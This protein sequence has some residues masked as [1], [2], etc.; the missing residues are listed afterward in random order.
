M[1]AYDVLIGGKSMLDE[2]GLKI[3]SYN[4]GM[5]TP[6]TQLIE[7][8]G[9][10]NVVDL[11][12]SFGDVQYKQRPVNIVM[13]TIAGYADW[14]ALLSAVAGYLHGQR[15]QIIFGT[16]V[17]FYYD[18]RISIDY[19]KSNEVFS[20][21]VLKGTAHPYKKEVENSDGLWLWDPFSFIDGVI[22][23]YANID[24]PGTVTIIGRR[25]KVV[26]VFT[27]SAAMTVTYDS[28][29][30]DLESGVNTIYALALGEG[31]H[32][33]TFAGVGTVSVAYRGGAL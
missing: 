20:T 24:S 22:R 26:P 25:E 5:P 13:S 28:V 21:I 17:A 2:Y 3:E 8:T 31:E 12:E 15:M 32:I 27:C 29:T 33:L 19:D 9:T 1:I 23:N 30:Y 6:I 11:T 7:I 14:Q 16:D 18:A 4:V 10:S